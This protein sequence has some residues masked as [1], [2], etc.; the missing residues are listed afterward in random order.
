MTKECPPGKVLN[1][2]TNRCIKEKVPKTNSPKKEKTAK[3]IKESP[4]KE[5][6][7]QKPKEAKAIRVDEQNYIVRNAKY[8]PVIEY[9]SICKTY[10]SLNP[11]LKM[12]SKT[13]AD[14]TQ[15]DIKFLTGFPREV[16]KIDR[17]KFE[18]F[19]GPYGFYG[20]YDNKNIKLSYK[21]VNELLNGVVNVDEIKKAIAA[22]KS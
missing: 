3:P 18:L 22:K 14:I 19:Y 21:L 9:D 15:Q 7:P 5:K 8:G 12:K 11:Y 4:K 1:P 2:K 13:L 17:K 20:K 10:L 16:G 6:A